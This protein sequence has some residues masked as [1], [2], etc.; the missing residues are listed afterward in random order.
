MLVH[1]YAVS[2][3]MAV[4][5]EAFLASAFDSKSSLHPVGPNLIHHSKKRP[6]KKSG[7][8]KSFIP[9]SFPIRFWSVEKLSL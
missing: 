4:V 9:L 7:V 3:G 1:Y 2:Q 6:R 5:S 8:L